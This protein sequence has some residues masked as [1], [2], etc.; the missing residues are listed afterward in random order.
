MDGQVET[1][2]DVLMCIYVL[3]GEVL[4]RMGASTR[5]RTCHRHEREL[6]WTLSERGLV[7]ASLCY[8]VLW[9]VLEALARFGYLGDLEGLC[10]AGGFW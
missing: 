7:P 9:G 1:W 5:S 4:P 3:P 10:E 8:L 2:V 6:A